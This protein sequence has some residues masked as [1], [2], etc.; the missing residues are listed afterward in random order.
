M[1]PNSNLK[2]NDS[3]AY[4]PHSSC[5]HLLPAQL[6]GGSDDGGMKRAALSKK[7][8]YFQYGHLDT[9]HALLFDSS[10]DCCCHNNH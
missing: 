8:L 5:P 3:L 6:H 2:S 9:P 10:I 4:P 1:N 7:N